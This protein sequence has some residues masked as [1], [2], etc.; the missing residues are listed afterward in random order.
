MKTFREDRMSPFGR[1]RSLA[2]ASLCLWSASALMAQ[3]TAPQLTA[4]RGL[5]VTQNDEVVITTTMLNATDLDAQGQA[6]DPADIFFVVGVDA[7]SP[8]V[9]L[10]TLLIRDVVTQREVQPLESI[11]LQDIQDGIVSYRADVGDGLF[12][13]FVFQ[14]KDAEGL[15]AADGEFSYFTFPIRIEAVNTAPIAGSVTYEAG[16]GEVVEETLPATD[17]DLPAQSLTFSLVD[18]APSKG[19]V[20]LLDATSGVF[21][22]SPNTGVSGTDVITF[23]VSDGEFS[24]ASSGTVTIAM[25]NRPPS[26]GDA[27]FTFTGGGA[28]IG[29]LSISDADLPAQ[30]LQVSVTKASE[31]GE[32]VLLEG[33]R[34]QYTPAVGRFGEDGFEVKVNDGFADSET[35]QVRIDVSRR[36]VVGDLFMTMKNR[37]DNGDA[38]ATVAL[39]DPDQFDFV[40]LSDGGLYE[41]P[42]ALVWSKWRGRI[43]AVEGEP[44]NDAQVLE[45]DPITG[46]QRVL[47][48]DPLVFPLGLAASDDGYL[49]IG[50]VA[51]PGSDSTSGHLYRVDLR[52]DS[53]TELN[54]DGIT[55]PTGLALTD[56]D[57]LY[58]LEAAD[59]GF[60][61]GHSNADATILQIDLETVTATTL[62]SGGLLQDPLGIIQLDDG[63]LLV[64]EFRGDIIRVSASGEQSLFYDVEDGSP[65]ISALTRDEND[66]I[67][68]VGAYFDDGGDSS[69]IRITSL[70]PP[71]VE[72][73]VSG[74]FLGQLF[75]LAAMTEHADY[76]TWV[77]AYFPHMDLVDVA[78]ELAEWADDMDP[79]GDTIPNLIEFA[80]NLSPLHADDPAVVLEFYLAQGDTDHLSLALF[81][82]LAHSELI[83]TLEVSANLETWTE[84]T[85]PA[86]E[87]SSGTSVIFEDTSDASANSPRFVRLKVTR[88]P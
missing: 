69:I 29:T 7:E 19:T 71:T 8:V 57:T 52:D 45:I 28:S 43:Y 58:V 1:L 49:Y 51:L 67:Y 59:I 66:T 65:I 4:N 64:T 62:T 33:G 70:D 61:A 77:H 17:N 10:G 80:L 54:V 42:L 86:A 76:D 79:D 85:T 15:V 18:P 30:D 14:V 73:V 75:G 20:E 32:V 35:A 23:Q 27:R 63:G 48:S 31:R 83:Y 46:E 50:D 13:G 26:V 87:S 72:T 44:G 25:V 40:G 81:R 2:G 84:I 41:S 22:Y 6:S 38:T 68:G 36:P 39:L 5:D 9:N 37:S 3:N 74:D 88:A 55:S 24:S 78:P 34:F 16:L 21:R 12:D 53:L 60:F 56:N 47:V 11:T 82:R